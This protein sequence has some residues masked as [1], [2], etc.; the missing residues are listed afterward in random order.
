M[1]NY[2]YKSTDTDWGFVRD[3]LLP[4]LESNGG[5]AVWRW[6][7]PP[8]VTVAFGSPQEI[9]AVRGAVWEVNQLLAE[10][11]MEVQ[12]SYDNSQ[13]DIEFTFISR[14]DFTKQVAANLEHK[15]LLYI[16]GF[17]FP[18]DHKNGQI[19]KASIVVFTNQSEGSKWGTILHELGHA[20]G[21][22]GHSSRHISSLYFKNHK[23][24]SFSDGFSTDDS[25]LLRFLYSH[26]EPGYDENKTREIFDT[27]WE[28]LAE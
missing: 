1:V 4:E 21:L 6:T 15:E 13:G 18:D 27:Y 26:L 20:L 2:E 24:G 16:K 14:A 7:Y 3:I 17:W 22:V 8:T 28:V 12:Y 5:P 23:G 11:T 19:K 25:K 9:A 10:T